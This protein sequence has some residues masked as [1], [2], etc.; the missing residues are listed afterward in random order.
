MLDDCESV[1][2]TLAYCS[3]FTLCVIVC[4]MTLKY[5]QNPDEEDDT[6]PLVVFINTMNDLRTFIFNRKRADSMN[7][8]IDNSLDTSILSIQELD[9][10]N[11]S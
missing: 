6:V 5:S 10:S 7:K 8:V 11:S 4:Y 1:S 9:V 3:D 2:Y